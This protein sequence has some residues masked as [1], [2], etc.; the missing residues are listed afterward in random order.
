[1]PTRSLT[2]AS[3]KRIKPPKQGQEDYFDRG[4]PGL[5][6]RVSYG[7]AKTWIYFY[8]LHGKLR[9]MSLGRFPGMELDE[10]RDAWRA[11]R[12]AV[13]KSESPAHIKPTAADTFAATA[14]EWLKR[15][16]AKNRSANEVRRAIDHDV[17]PAWADRLI[18]MIT[19]RDVLELI[20]G[21]ADRGA[22]TM[23]RRLHSHLHRLFRWAVGRGILEVNPM[24]DLPK[25]GAA[26]KR[27]RVLSDDELKAVWKAAEK[28]AWPFGPAVRLLI[29]TAARREEIGALRW[30][31]IHGDEIRI[32]GERSKTGEPRI[33]PLSPAALALIPD[34][35]RVGEYVFSANGS[36]ISGWSKA[37]RAIDTAA[38]EMNGGPLAPWRMH[39]IRRSVATN[40]QRLGIGLQV[41]ESIL[42][43]VGGSRAGIVGVYQRHQFLVEQKA[44]LEAWAQEVARI[45]S[46]KVQLASA[47]FAGSGSLA[48]TA[49]LNAV[50]GATLSGSGSLTADVQPIDMRWVKAV[51]QA[52]KTSSLDP[53][54]AHLQLPGVQ[55]RSSECLWLRM[56]LE[57]MQFRHK[58]RGRRVPLGQKSQ[59]QKYQIGVEHVRELQR[60][61]NGMSQQ[62]AIDT[63][64]K[65]YPEG[66]FGD[67][68]GAKLANF[69]KR[70][71]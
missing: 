23:A 3:V 26:V 59:K 20:D 29:L 21:V 11:A 13:S 39:D 8:R 71:Q 16:Q 43:H 31:E 22:L 1:M 37:K 55:L 41:V 18:A 5:A 46:G 32:P 44:A 17:M 33:I 65:I 7:G 49:N 42:G 6:L 14:E 60:T 52:Y 34:L 66:Y 15:D 53:V 51:E 63:V 2:V 70:G 68:Y 47:I 25:P 24:A 50:A 69:I 38:E 9:R 10:A 4:Y 62:T 27:D 19:R 61:N 48:A 54:I 45:T 35:N 57:Q 12:L 30:S 36:G 58:R 67:N 56:L 28:T 64:I 40:L